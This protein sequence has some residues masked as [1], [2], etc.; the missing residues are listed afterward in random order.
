MVISKEGTIMI[1]SRE[2]LGALIMRKKKLIQ[3]GRKNSS[4]QL[5]ECCGQ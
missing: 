4:I 2:E 3:I 5:I 1:N